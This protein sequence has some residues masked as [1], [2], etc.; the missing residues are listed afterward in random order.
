MENF[1]RKKHWENIY[2]TKQLEEVNW[3][4]PTPEVSLNFFKQFKVPVDDK[5]FDVGGGDSFLVDHLFAERYQNITVLDISEIAIEKAKK[6]LG[7]KASKVKW[8]VSDV[9]LKNRINI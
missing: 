6:H 9:T 3:Y 7:N 2:N 1:N 4:Q 8:I 5:I